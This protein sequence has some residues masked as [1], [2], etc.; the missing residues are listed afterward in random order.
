MVFTTGKNV[1][2]WKSTNQS[3]TYIEGRLGFTSDK[4]VDGNG[5]GNF[6]RYQTCTHTAVN[7]TH[8]PTWNVNLGKAYSIIAIKIANRNNNRKYAKT[9]IFNN[10]YYVFDQH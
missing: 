4:A 6:I 5:D 8:S 7:Q 1:A 2:V 9:S 10:I 3:N